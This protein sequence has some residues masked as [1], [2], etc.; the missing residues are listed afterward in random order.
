MSVNSGFLV[1]YSY[2]QSNLECL[3]D[4][5][6]YINRNCTKEDGTNGWTAGHALNLISDCGPVNVTCHEE[7]VSGQ[8]KYGQYFN[9][10]FTLYEGEYCNI[11]VDASLGVA[12][13]IFDETSYLG[14]YQ[15][16]A[17]LGEVITYEENTGKHEMTIFNA[18]TSGPITFLISFSNAVGLGTAAIASALV[19][20]AIF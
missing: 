19:A 17:R 20:T 6:N 12:R 1:S 9:K 7:F 11:T 16:D 2:C 15:L 5:W 8:D 14:L 10:T 13:V 4:A 3:E 18:A